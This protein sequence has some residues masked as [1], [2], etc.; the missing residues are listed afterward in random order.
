MATR[1]LRFPDKI[2]DLLARKYAAGRRLWLA[3]EGTWPLTISLGLPNEQEAQRHGDVVGRW[4]AAWQSWHGPGALEWHERQWR[5]MGTQ[6]LPKS[7]VLANAAEAAAWLGE[8]ERWQGACA[9][10]RRL[11]QRWPALA[12]RLPRYFDVLADYS[13]SDFDRLEATL[14]W[15]GV[16]RTSSLYPRQLP[17][18]GVDSK[19]VEGRKGLLTNLVAAL[20]QMD[21]EGADFFACCGLRP[22]PSLIRVRLLDDALRACA[23]GLSDI[24]APAGDLAKLSLPVQHVFIVENTQTGLAFEDLPGA[25]VLM[26][27]GYGVDAL[28][29]LTWIAGKKCFYWGDLDTH[30][31]AI[32]SHVRSILPDAE[33]ILMDGPTLRNNKA[34]WGEEPQQHPASEL[35]RLTDKEQDLF[36]GLKEQRWGLNIRLEQERV[37]WTQA[38]SA[39]R[40]AAASH[41]A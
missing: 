21:A 36:R 15:F 41:Q 39:L 40:A 5:S 23:G 35:P 31:F 30:G 38:W 19:W 33:S 10:Y 26:G 14:A 32:L 22:P 7:L 1:P 6:R 29:Q 9:R 34:L 16:N 11:N 2:R 37:P 27:L 8:T 18:P 3:G 20:H 24:S 4:I 13:E 17:I 28:G 12:N 25:A